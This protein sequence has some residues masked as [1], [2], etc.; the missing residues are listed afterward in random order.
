[1]APYKLILALE[2]I[3]VR[4][5]REG[6]IYK[7]DSVKMAK[8][9]RWYHQGVQADERGVSKN[10]TKEEMIRRAL[11]NIEKTLI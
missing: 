6:P 1:M 3:N 8:L 11:S 4:N 7:T 9:A 2:K 5:M 10:E